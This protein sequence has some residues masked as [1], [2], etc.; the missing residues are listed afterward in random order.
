LTATDFILNNYKEITIMQTA[1]P[2]KEEITKEYRGLV[3]AISHRMIQ[4]PEIA[5]DA[6][7]EAWMEILKSL[8]TFK[9][10][11]KISTWIYTI[12]SRVILR[13][14]KNEK[15]Y[16]TR[17]LSEYFRNGERESP[18]EQE[19]DKRRWVKEMCDKCLTGI[20]HCLSSQDRLL[21]ILYD[22]AGLSYR[23]LSMIVDDQE[24]TVRK[25][26]SRS[27]KKLHN[28]LNEEC[29]LFKPDG[30]CSCRMKKHVVDIDLPSEYQKLK[31]T[32]KDIHFFR[33]SRQIL[34]IKDHLA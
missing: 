18:F 10:E 6:A 8:K 4:N 19:A 32:V 22:V 11:S 12:A 13:Q 26:V 14:A 30:N 15:I 17:Y 24:S 1:F 28:F 29:V 20:L 3:S 9:G 16:S 2:T 33:E 31:N 23:E 25:K 21:Y 5:K 27:R 34:A 7:Q